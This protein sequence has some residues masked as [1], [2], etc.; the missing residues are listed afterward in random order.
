MFEIWKAMRPG[1]PDNDGKDEP[2]TMSPSMIEE[3][4]LHLVAKVFLSNIIQKLFESPPMYR[5]TC[6][7]LCQNICEIKRDNIKGL[8]PTTTLGLEVIDKECESWVSRRD[9]PRRQD[10]ANSL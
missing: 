7:A 6:S 10:H 8:L 3:I 4:G 5:A 2:S 1:N 9:P